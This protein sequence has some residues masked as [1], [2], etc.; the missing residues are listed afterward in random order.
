LQ[1]INYQPTNHKI[2]LQNSTGVNGRQ[3][4]AATASAGLRVCD[5]IHQHKCPHAGAEA[6]EPSE[7]RIGCEPMFPAVF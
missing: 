2:K 4:F 7:T 6:C 3:T 1:P 5:H